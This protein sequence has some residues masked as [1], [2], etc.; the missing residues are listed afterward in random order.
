M[1]KR[2]SKSHRSTHRRARTSRRP[3]ESYLV[4]V[5]SW[6]LVV[7]FAIM[8]GVGAVVGT[9]LNSQMNESSPQVAGY[10]IEAE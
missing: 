3:S 5:R 7:L 10:T 9:F 6:M 8:L 1:K 4:V 2:R